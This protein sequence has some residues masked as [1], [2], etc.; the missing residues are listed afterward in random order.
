[1]I[2]SLAAAALLTYASVRHHE[3]V[4]YDDRAYILENPLL[5]QPLSAASLAAAFRPYHD[6]WIPL[7]W[8]SLQIDAALFG[9]QPAGFLATN[10]ALHTASAIVLLLAL[11]RMTGA[12]G[13]SAFV[14]GVFALHPLHVESVAWASERK[15]VLAG[16]FWMLALLAH[17]KHAE[18]GTY[19]GAYAGV[20]LFGALGMMSKPSVVSLPLA[21]LIL[22]Y[23][24]LGRLAE[25]R[26]RRAALLEKLPLLALAAIVSLVTLAVQQS[27]DAM[28]FGSQLPLSVRLA[29]ALEA[30]GFYL[31][32]SFWPSGLAAFYPLDPHALTAAR[33]GAW[34]VLLVTLSAVAITQARRRP[35]L[36][37]GWAWFLVTLLPSLGLVQVGLQARADRYTY[38]PLVGIALA[39]AWTAADLARPH[40]AWRKAVT[41]CAWV[42]LAGLGIAAS[43]QVS[44]WSDTHSLFERAANVTSNNFYAHNALA[45]L[46]LESGRIERAEHHYREAMRQAPG[47]SR[48]R[49]GLASIE[50]QRDRP[51]Q[52]EPLLRKALDIEPRYAPGH[53]QLGVALLALDAADEALL[54]LELARTLGLQSAESAG[55]LGVAQARVGRDR[56]A[57]EHLEHARAEN[58]DLFAATLELAWLRL[59]SNHPQVRDPLEARQLTRQ[60]MATGGTARVR[61]LELLAAILAEQ[62]DFESAG[63]RV[64]QAETLAKRLGNAPLARA[65][66]R[67]RR[68]YEGGGTVASPVRVSPASTSATTVNNPAP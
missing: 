9:L 59:G 16:L 19:A 7:T 61:G 35:F 28:V 10:L 13:C 62:E 36:L 63:Q 51:A 56:D 41:A 20:C 50:L 53:L 37:V 17:A 21:L 6:N 27:A 8:I 47:W 40:P 42:T 66:G 11:T 43:Q 1:M 33:S 58:P 24:P 14:A 54:H 49:I 2:A 15:D 31:Q 22:D 39:V 64:Q 38:I 65:L 46:H 48:P 55:A 23:W 26:S 30:Y 57:I 52:A 3:F 60:L 5:E 45:G 67:A 44:Y 12:L 68:V 32:K 29:N 34:A 4:N 25:A 18:R